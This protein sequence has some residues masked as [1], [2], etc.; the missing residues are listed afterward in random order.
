MASAEEIYLC[1]LKHNT[2]FARRDGTG[3]LATIAG[4]ANLKNALLRRL[5]TEPGSLVHRPEYG[6]GIKRYQNAPATLSNKRE[7]ALRI[8]DQF[9]RDSRVE[10]VLGVQILIDDAKPSYSTIIVRVKIVG[11]GEG[12]FDFQPFGEV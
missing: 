7:L 10:D 5:V 3:D 12:S 9:R 2:D 11:Y 1:D 4:L 6:V 8:S